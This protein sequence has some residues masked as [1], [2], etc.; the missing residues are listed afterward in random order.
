MLILHIRALAALGRRAD[1]QAQW[2]WL[3][4]ITPDDTQTLRREFPWLTKGD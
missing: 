4:S 2:R 1:A 3:D